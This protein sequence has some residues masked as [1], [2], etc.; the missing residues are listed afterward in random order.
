MSTHLFD[1]L[2]VLRER[3]EQRTRDVLAACRDAEHTPRNAVAEAQTAA[4]EKR[5]SRHAYA[6][7]WGPQGGGVSSVADQIAGRVHLVRLDGEVAQCALMLTVAEKELAAAVDATAA[8]AL[9]L[10][11]AQV[12]TQKSWHNAKCHRESMQRERLWAEEAE[13]DEETEMQV[14]ARFMR[15]TTL[16][17][18]RYGRG[19]QDWGKGEPCAASRGDD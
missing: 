15:S 2:Q 18:G 1:Q 10:K 8:S 7:Q 19:A 3:R 12:A 9:K 5:L 16:N 11:T 17:R 6:G 14:T 4:D 13:G